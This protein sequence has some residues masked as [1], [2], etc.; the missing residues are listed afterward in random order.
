MFKKTIFATD[1]SPASD[2]VLKCLK[3][4]REIGVEQIVLTHALGIRH[5]DDLRY[6][7]IR[8]VEPQWC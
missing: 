8:M 2:E 7:L 4:L 6:E 3:S 5:L 1:L